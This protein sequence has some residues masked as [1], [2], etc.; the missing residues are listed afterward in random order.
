MV[1][2]MLLDTW[3]NGALSATFSGLCPGKISMKKW[4]F[5]RNRNHFLKISHKNLSNCK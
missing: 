1:V 3:T 2:P 5:I 4:L